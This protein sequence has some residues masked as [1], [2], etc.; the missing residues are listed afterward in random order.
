MYIKIHKPQNRYGY[1]NTGSCANLVSY[2]EKE[3]IEKDLLD[4]SYFF[5][6]TDE[7]VFPRQV[8]EHIDGN[9][10]WIK[11]NEAKYYMLTLNPSKAELTHLKNDPEKLKAYTREVMDIYARQ[12]DRKLDGKPLSGK[13]LVYYA[14]IEQSR[15]YHP[16]ERIY[17]ESY[18]H[19]EEI[20]ERLTTLKRSLRK[21]QD[22]SIKL[23]LEKEMEALTQSYLRDEAGNVIL[24][25]N[26]KA[27]MQTHIHVIVSRK[28]RSQCVS[29]SP[30]ANSRGSKN[31]LKG[32]SV[33]VGFDRDEFTENCEQLFDRQF[34]Y[35]RSREESYR[36]HYYRKH[37]ASRFAR[38]LLY[39]PTSPKALARKLVL[40]L[41]KDSPEIQ[42]LVRKGLSI[43][44]RAKVLNRTIEQVSRQIEAGLSPGTVAVKRMMEKSIQVVKKVGYGIEI[45]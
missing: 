25:G 19:N 14:K 34:Q 39:I 40:Q 20:R 33:R 11:K 13:D 28:D 35:Q 12:F 38:E 23:E 6:A 10:K 7:M 41:L 1:D 16:S 2:L 32:R 26:E 43:R 3:N 27:G 17:Q 37:E 22:L 42:K 5:S 21:T 30:F 31:Q 18:V 36:Y 29:L 24:A 4:H 44:H 9:K 15:Y 45:N 8:T